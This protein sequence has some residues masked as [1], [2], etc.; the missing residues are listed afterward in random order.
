MAFFA[1]VTAALAFFVIGYIPKSEPSLVVAIWFHAASLASLHSFLSG[2]HSPYHAR[3]AVLS[4]SW[5][6]SAYGL[7]KPVGLVTAVLACLHHRVHPRSEPAPRG[8]PMISCSLPGV[9]E[10]VLAMSAPLHL[11][12]SLCLRRFAAIECLPGPS[13]CQS[14]LLLGIPARER[15]DEL[16]ESARFAKQI[17]LSSQLEPLQDNVVGHMMKT[18]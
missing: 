15:I 12:G 4:T 16:N 13:A 11:Q 1:A 2:K 5:C 8:C 7:C 9:R 14:A 3:A 18:R 17:V 10:S 6:A